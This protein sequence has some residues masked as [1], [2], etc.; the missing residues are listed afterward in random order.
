M[1]IADIAVKRPVLTS[2]IVIVFVLFGYIAFTRLNLNLFPDVQIPYVTVQCVYPGAGPKEIESLVTKKLEDAVSTIEGIESIDSYSLDGV[3][4][5]LIEFAL[6]KDVDVA[7]QEVKDKVD[8]I[9]NDLPEDAL[10]PIISKVDFRAFPVANLVLSGDV[11]PM[12]LYEFADKVVRDKLSQVKGV[13]NVTM[14]GGQEKEI[15][16]TLSGKTIYENMLSLPAFMGILG[17][18]NFDIPGGTFSIGNQDYSVRLK[19]QY[20]SLSTILETDIPTAFGLKKIRELADVQFTGKKVSQRT[21]FNDVKNN[22]RYE[23]AI[24]MGLIKSPD[25][26]VVEVVKKVQEKLPEILNDLPEGMQLQMVNESATFVESSSSDTLGNI[27][28]GVILTALVL[29]FF[30]HDIRSTFIAAITMPASI[31]SSFLLFPFV[32]LD[33]NMMSLMGIS[34]TVG[35]LVANSVVIIENIFRYKDLGYS[36]KDATIKGTNEVF[37]AVLASTLTNLVVFIPLANLES[38]V[39][40]FLKAL[41]LSATF[42]TIFSLIYSFTLTP[43]LTALIVSDKPKK[44]GAITSFLTK[45]FDTYLMKIYEN[46]LT[47]TLKNKKMAIGAVVSSIILFIVVLMG[48]GPKLGFEFQPSFD[49]GLLTARVELPTGYNVESTSQTIKNIEDVIKTH[50]EV[51]MLVSTIGKSSNV[52]IGTNLA[53]ISIYLVDVKERTKGIDELVIDITNDLSKVPN[54]KINVLAGEGGGEGGSAPVEFFILGQNENEVQKI[55]DKVFENLKTIPGLINFE[56]S[57]RS[58]KPEMTVYPNRTRLAEVGLNVSDLAMSLRLA[59]EGMSTSKYKFKGEEYDITIKMNSDETDSPEE[60]RNMPIATRAGVFRLA[61]LGDIQFTPGPTKV[62]HRN[63]YTAIKFTGAPGAGIPLGDITSEVEKRIEKIDM[64]TGYSFAWGGSAKLFKQMMADLTFAFAI[65][66]LLTYFLLA[67]ILESFVQPL[68]IMFTVP[69]GLIGVIVFS[70]IT[71]T[72]MSI[73]AMMGVILLTGVV[74]NNAILMLDFANQ[75]VREEG[76]HI[77][78]ALIFASTTKLMPIIMSNAALALGML[79]LA[80]GIGDAGVEIRIPL[81]IVTIGGIFAST[82]LTLLVIPALYLIFAKEKKHKDLV[83]I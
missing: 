79:P 23:N 25:G 36:T 9:T 12:E 11:E 55:S 71:G 48:L 49:Q 17:Q 66:I 69:L 27:Y 37:V 3:T 44:K 29:L 15:Q 67:A 26:N 21:I 40:Q 70:Y 31:L 62:L 35:V 60:I 1:R 54:A 61:E 76:K 43:M 8:Q 53:T 7:N 46:I 38:T 19:G 78:E 2:V 33:L 41:A 68:Y 28:I 65:G 56:Q 32:G 83:Q 64:P 39:G 30:L 18:Q 4:F 77:R 82:V 22:I 10:K 81:G 74:V 5:V 14:D 51:K 50:P 57:T 6:G 13:A 80:L 75:L 58:G 59:L 72:T 16:V 42:T 47:F 20:D 34:V 45:Y 63:K 24:Q 52:D 73:T